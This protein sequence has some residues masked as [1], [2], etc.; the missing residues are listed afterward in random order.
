MYASLE[1]LYRLWDL[2]G[3]TPV[4]DNGMIEEEFLGFP[5]GTDREDIWHWFE[6]CNPNFVCG[7]VM[8]GRRRTA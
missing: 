6:D 1:I 4:T 3:N 7:E 2:F 8:S 5:I